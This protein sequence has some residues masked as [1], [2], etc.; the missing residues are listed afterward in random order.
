M[1]ARYRSLTTLGVSAALASLTVGGAVAQD[2]LPD[3][4]SN[5]FTPSTLRV[6]PETAAPEAAAPGATTQSVPSE[7]IPTGFLREAPAAFDNRTN[8]F[9]VQGP[10]FEDLD[11]DNVVALRSFND[12]R[13]VFEEVEQVAD[14]LGPTYNAQACRECHPERARD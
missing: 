10:A 13:F 11:A 4:E 14:G 2:A 7:P 5:R 3:A 9:D 8:G 6:D 12:N 1:L